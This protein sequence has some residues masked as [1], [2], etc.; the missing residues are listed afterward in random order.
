VSKYTHDS[1]F[2]MQIS[3][4]ALCFFSAELAM[5][6][7]FLAISSIF[8]CCESG[9]LNT[10]T[11]QK[12]TADITHPHTTHNH[13]TKKCHTRQLGGSL[14]AEGSFAAVG[15]LGAVA[16]ARQRGGGKCSLAVAGSLT[17]SASARQRCGGSSS[18]VV[19][20]N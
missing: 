20:G 8:T 9:W 3:H 15:S 2:S 16:A 5:G 1:Y 14:A 4:Y 11:H 7:I 13:T 19:V 18:L 17:A 10:I 6:I 12:S